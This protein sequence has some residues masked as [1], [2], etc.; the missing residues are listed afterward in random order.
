MKVVVYSL[1]V[2]ASLVLEF[3]FITISIACLFA[4]RLLFLLVVCYCHRSLAYFYSPTEC[5]VHAATY[6]LDMAFILYKCISFI[7]WCL[8]LEAKGP[9]TVSLC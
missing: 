5:P 8:C 1:F 4:L 3:F 9:F 6:G 7:D 2:V